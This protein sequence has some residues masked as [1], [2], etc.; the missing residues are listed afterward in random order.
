MLVVA[1][2]EQALKVLADKVPEGIRDLT[3]SVLGA[4]EE[5]RKRLGQSI[6][7]IQ[8]RVGQVDRAVA[9]ARIVELTAFLDALDR[10]Y[11]DVTTQLL[12][13]R[14]GRWWG[15]WGP[16]HFQIQ[17]RVGQV[18]RAVADARIV[19]LTAF[20]DALDRRYAEVTTQLLRTRR[21]EVTELPGSWPVTAPVT[22]QAAAAWIAENQNQLGYIP[23]ALS[24][25]VPVPLTSGELAELLELLRTVGLD[26]ASRAGDS[27]PDRSRLPTPADLQR[28]LHRLSELGARGDRARH[29]IRDWG[30]VSNAGGQQ[31]RSLTDDLIRE[32]DW[33]VKLASGWLG[34]VLEQLRDPLMANEWSTFSQDLNNIREQVIALR[35]ALRAHTIQLP[36]TVTQEFV[37]DLTSARDKLTG[38]GKL[39]LFAKDAK[40]ATEACRIDGVIPTTLEQVQ[41]CLDTVQVNALRYRIAVIWENQTRPLGAPPL[42]GYPEQVIRDRLDEIDEVRS[43]QQRWT[44]LTQRLAAAGFPIPQRPSAEALEQAASLGQDAL[45]GLEQDAIR[46]G[47]QAT[48]DVLSTGANGARPS[49]TWLNLAEAVSAG[50]LAGY[51]Q[52]WDAVE[53]LEA[54]A[55]PAARL[56]ELHQRLAAVAPEWAGAIGRDPNSGRPTRR[57]RCRVAMAPARDVAGRDRGAARPGRTAG[58]SRGTDPGAPPNGDGAGHRAGLATARGQ[59]RPP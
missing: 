19:E 2:K 28:Q 47:L 25:S 52:E 59:P 18:D 45:A 40:R 42:V 5:G 22:P 53:Q 35:T 34:R 9:D 57:P 51:R 30:R 31:I 54:V 23:D 15:W 58:G 49:P 14:R 8:S 4:D 12:R 56:T 37:A 7:K 39:G 27:L 21:A 13:T 36:E 43:S 3:V 16:V 33:Y 48:R 44:E 20:L 1:E 26:K 46:S 6:S 10:R 11:A 55:L 24:T 17:S 50:D 38:G 32:R 41:R 29:T